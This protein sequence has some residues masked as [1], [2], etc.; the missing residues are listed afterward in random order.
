MEDEI[1]SVRDVKKLC[2]TSDDDILI[3]DLQ[4]FAASRCPSLKKIE[5]HI[6]PKSFEIYNSLFLYTIDRLVHLEFHFHYASDANDVIFAADKKAAFKKI[7]QLV[8]IAP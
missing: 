3:V 4:C 2:K 1:A 6:F 5:M 8:C 7:E